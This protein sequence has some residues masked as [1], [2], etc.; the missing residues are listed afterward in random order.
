MAQSPRV[1]TNVESTSNSSFT[2]MQILNKRLLSLS[3]AGKSATAVTCETHEQEQAKQARK[4]HSSGGHKSLRQ[5]AVPPFLAS[6]P[7]QSKQIQATLQNCF[8]AQ[9]LNAP[10]R[11]LVHAC[12]HA[13]WRER[14]APP[15]A[16]MCS[17]E[18]VLCRG[19]S[20]V[21]RSRGRTR[22]RAPRPGRRPRRG[23]S[24]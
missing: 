22:Q 19:T 6:P 17:R 1:S 15:A 21:H 4:V 5:A 12:M 24:S 2:G 20:A 13:A 9:P 11:A 7:S 3:T 8:L 18:C 23:A 16:R 10:S 14:R